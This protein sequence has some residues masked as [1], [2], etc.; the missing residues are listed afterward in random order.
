MQAT[1]IDSAEVEKFSR[2]AEAWW[3]EK[4]KFRTL[5]LLNPLRIGYIRDKALTQ[6]G[7][8]DD[9]QPFAGLKILDI[10]C[11]GGLL[12]EPMAR[13]GASVTGIDVSEKNIKIA[14]AHLLKS[15]LDVDY[16]NITVEELAE[17]GEKFDIILNMEVIEHVSDINLFL[18]SCATLLKP[19]GIMFIST[20]NRTAKSFALAIIGA[21]YVLRLLPRGT[22]D[23]K[24]FLKPSEI[25]KL[26]AAENIILKH[27]TGVAFNPLNETVKTTDD[28]AV[29]YMMYYA[30]A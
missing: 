6:L 27:M 26:L 4:G 13:L 18:K 28:L 5:H 22:H 2:L 9:L 24:K 3:D 21:E 16:K 8:P 23:W 10:G 12:S 30:K 15:G 14:T 17:S 20:I 11:G 19:G 7:L 1:T 29:N 25:N